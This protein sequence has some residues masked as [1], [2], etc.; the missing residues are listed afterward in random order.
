MLAEI[1]RRGC[2]YPPAHVQFARNYAESVAYQDRLAEAIGLFSRAG[3]TADELAARHPELAGKIEREKSYALNACGVAW[4]KLG[5]FPR[6]VAVLVEARDIFRR[7]PRVDRTGEAEA[8]TNLATALDAAGDPTRAQFALEEALDVVR[9]TKDYDQ[10]FR[11]LVA[12]GRLGL[13]LFPAERMLELVEA[14]ALAALEGGRPGIAYVRFCTGASLAVG[15]DGAAEVGLGMVRRAR[16]IEGRL[17]PNDPHVPK[18]R[19]IEAHL[20]RRAGRPGGE[21]TRALMEGAHH[22][23]RLLAVPLVPEDFRARTA[24]LHQHF[25][26]LAGCLLESGL[27]E[28]SLVAFEAG[29]ALGYAVEADPE[30]FARVVRRNPFAEDGS[31]VDLTLLRDAQRELGSD[32][33]AVVLAVIPRRLV[34]YVVD[35]DNVRC[36]AVDA[37]ATQADLDYLDTEI[38]IL[39]RQLFKGVGRAA[40]HNAIF[41]LAEGV[42]RQVGQRT[43]T[44]LIPYDSLHLVPWRAVLRECGLPWHQLAYVVGFNLLLSRRGAAGDASGMPAV[45][46]LGHGMAGGIDLQEEARDFAAAFGDRGRLLATCTAVQVTECLESDAVVLLSCHG[47]AVEEVGEVRLVLELSDGPQRAETIFP[48]HVCSPLVILSACDSGVYYMAW[49]DY[50]VGAGPSLIRR[51]AGAV[52]GARFQVRAEFAATFFARF[53][54]ALASGADVRRA[55]TLALEQVDGPDADL[56][57]DLACLELLGSA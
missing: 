14:G 43:L 44:R 25:R 7:Q 47:R 16:G 50:P 1:G 48:D 57:R 31:A 3:E 42:A 35:R 12:G 39:P 4:L 52:I 33:A 24:D 40:V 21:I 55:F 9:G 5:E 8:L 19:L 22:W 27:L 2:L 36:E 10:L 29:R 32:E 38:K 41:A 20:L 6:A 34:A 13:D 51:G 53:A 26:L 56:W 28:E 17:D 54:R 45:I 37:A 18:L 30:F 11:V 15:R 46:T 23:Y 49:S